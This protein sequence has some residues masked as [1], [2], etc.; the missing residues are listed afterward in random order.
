MFEPGLNQAG[1]AGGAAHFFV[2]GFI[3]DP[4][5]KTGTSMSTVFALRRATVDVVL[6]LGLL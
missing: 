1:C 6:I 3:D 2:S 5:V 4:Q